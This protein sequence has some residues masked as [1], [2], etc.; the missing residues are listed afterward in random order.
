MKTK[1]I[2]YSVIIVS[3]LA[4]LL[5]TAFRLEKMRSE[6]SDR[7]DD[8]KKS[9]LSSDLLVKESEG[10]YAKLVDYYNTEKDLRNQLK[11]S[12][13]DLYRI[14]KKQDERLLSITSS[15]VSLQN[16]LDEGFGK[17]N[18]A[19]SNQI[20]IKLT[21]PTQIDPFITWNGYVDKTTAKYKGN[22]QFGK[23]P[24]Q[25]VV[26]EESRGLWK[27]RII[28]P[29]WFIVDS[30]TVNSIPPIKY[31]PDAPRKIQFLAGGG[32]GIQLNAITSQS[33][34]QAGVGL[35]IFDIHTII[36][37]ANTLQQISLNYFYTFKSTKRN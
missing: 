4:V 10:R 33:Y 28:G 19:D 35:K 21:Y 12:N 31:T 18:S 9:I 27:H 34:V 3:L 7:T 14:I 26:T 6:M 2:F 1:D 36:F 16:K 17:F 11:R 37:Q 24:I 15:V 30:L 13:E 25:I 23:L 5:F 8:L 22:W 29:D 20:D 32:Y